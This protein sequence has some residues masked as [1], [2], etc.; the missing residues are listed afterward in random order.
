MK[1]LFDVL[2]TVPGYREFDVSA[3]FMIALPIFS[4]I[5]ISD[6]GYG[7]LYLLAPLVFYRKMAAAGAGLLAKLVIVVGVL[8]LAWGLAT[9]SFFGFDISGLMGLDAPPIAV[10]TAKVNMN[11][12]MRISFILAAIPLSFAHVWLAKKA[13]PRLKCVGE[14]GWAVFLWGMFGVVNM[15]LLGDVFVGTVYPYLLMA[16]GAL[17]VLFA[18]PDR[19]VL[20]M[21]GVGVAK[22]PLAALGTL[23]DTISYVRL[24]A[25]GV[26]GTALALAFNDMA[27]AVPLPAG[28]P[29]LIVGHAL[30]VALSV[31]S[32][33]AHGVRLNVLEFSN[34]LGMQWSGYPYEPFSAER[35]EEN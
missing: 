5:M 14:L 33:L 22:F 29:I 26:A 24:M 31:V 32:L 28:I 30:N 34:N 17:A 20:K 9:A 6:A 8:S 4:A 23:G 18:A 11:F 12:L 25:L 13:F 7:L 35:S 10:T 27:S 16:G 15:L 2:G 1:G 3:A 19:N 21:V